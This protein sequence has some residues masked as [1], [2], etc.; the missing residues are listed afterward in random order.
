M[1][2]KVMVLGFLVGPMY[3]KEKKDRKSNLVTRNYTFE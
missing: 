1:C 2:I 3:F